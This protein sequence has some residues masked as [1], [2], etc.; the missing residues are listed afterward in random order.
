MTSS[1]I[2]FKTLVLVNHHMSNKSIKTYRN[3]IM[4]ICLK[5]SFL[6]ERNLRVTNRNLTINYKP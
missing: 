6:T 3:L 2:C 1:N 5:T 4:K